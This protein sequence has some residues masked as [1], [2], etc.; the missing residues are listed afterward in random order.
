MA[1]GIN[2][3]QETRP[4]HRPQ[5]GH[6]GQGELPDFATLNSSTPWEARVSHS[7]TLFTNA[8]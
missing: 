4:F 1:I 6:F 5:T 3:T 8:L 2:T 7:F